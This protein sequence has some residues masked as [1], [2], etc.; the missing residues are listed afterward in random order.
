LHWI[1]LSQTLV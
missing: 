1:D